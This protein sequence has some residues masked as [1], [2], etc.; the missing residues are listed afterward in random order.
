MR[1]YLTRIPYLTLIIDIPLNNTHRLLFRV[2]RDQHGTSIDLHGLTFLDWLIQS[3]TT[4]SDDAGA[5]IWFD[6]FKMLTERQCISRGFLEEGEVH[7]TV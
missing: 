7:R 5:H 6:G 1:T 4:Q 2:R 3:R